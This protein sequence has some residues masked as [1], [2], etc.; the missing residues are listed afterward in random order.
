MGFSSSMPEII[1]LMA[2][3]SAATTVLNRANRPP[4]TQGESAGQH[5]LRL[6]S[7]VTGFHMKVMPG[8]LIGSNTDIGANSLVMENI[9]DDMIVYS[10]SKLKKIAK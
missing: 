3:S 10:E 2:T 9:K 4:S 1:S 6:L 8:V 7:F 5:T